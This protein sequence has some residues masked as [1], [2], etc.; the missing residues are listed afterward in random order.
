MLGAIL[1]IKMTFKSLFSPTTDIIENAIATIKNGMS[2]KFVSRQFGIPRT[3]VFFPLK[4]AWKVHVHKWT[5]DNE[6]C[7][8]TREE[9][10]SLL[11][12]TIKNAI[13]PNIITNEFKGCGL[14]PFNVD[15]IDC[16]KYFKG[17][18]TNPQTSCKLP[19]TTLQL[20]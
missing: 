19:K 9:I 7:K 11:D 4:T 1:L 15:A 18:S 6:G 12:K 14:Y 17:N 5:I 3:T 8:L 16:K 20:H 10:A 2:V 13:T